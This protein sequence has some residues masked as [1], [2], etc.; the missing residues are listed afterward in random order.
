[1]SSLQLIVMASV[2]FSIT[3]GKEFSLYHVLRY[4]HLT[5]GSE[6]LVSLMIQAVKKKCTVK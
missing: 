2:F 5:I 3:M 6:T 1:M 4:D